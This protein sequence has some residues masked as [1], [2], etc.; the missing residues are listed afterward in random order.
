MDKELQA[1]FEKLD[2]QYFT[3]E[4]KQTIS[5]FFSEALEKRVADRV[6]LELGAMDDTHAEQTKI[7]LDQ[8]EAT[9]EAFKADVD[10]DHCKKIQTVANALSESFGQKLTIVKEGYEKVIRET[11]LEHRTQ[12]VGAVDKHLTSYLEKTI[13]IE[14]V[15]ESAKN[16]FAQKQIDEA[17]KILGI[18]KAF[19]SANVREGIVQGKQQMDALI[20]ENNALKKSKM[21]TES[22]SLLVK[23][24]ANL[25]AEQRKY[26]RAKLEGRSPAFI[27]D[28]ISYV[29]EMYARQETD[30]KTSLLREHK[31]QVD[32][33]VVADELGKQNSYIVESTEHNPLNP[34][35]EMYKR[36]LSYRK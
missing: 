22:E 17:R 3:D 8:L 28:N 25:P 7:V 6:S 16:T 31:S 18:D 2:A 35:M 32:R 33:V 19:I 36:G 15:R 29:L 12:L 34:H 21:V 14:Q 24:T 5:G 30:E 13:P 23:A 20:K 27:K 10:K 4:L 26:V 1:I 9:F 11:A